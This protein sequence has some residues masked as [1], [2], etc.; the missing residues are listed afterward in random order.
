MTKDVKH[1]QTRPETEGGNFSPALC[2]ALG[3]LLL[4]AVILSALPLA[5]PRMLG[6]EVYSVVSGSMEP[7]LPV[8]S[9]VYVE[10]T[11]VSEIRPGEIIAFQDDDT[12]VTH[13][14]I[15]TRP[16]E[17][18]FITKGDANGSV[19]IQPTPYWTL[20]GRVKLCIPMLGRLLTVYYTQ[21]GKVALAFF[22][23]SGLLFRMLASRMRAHL[24]RDR[25]EK[26]KDQKKTE[27]EETK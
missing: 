14:V 25:R 2:S 20:I 18:A 9:I 3:T 13:R 1:Q 11:G 7:T 5:V 16:Q 24:E 10:R 12:V 19:D 17:G 15:E 27:Q 6:Y 22:A 4:L 23:M 26:A 21:E 8:G